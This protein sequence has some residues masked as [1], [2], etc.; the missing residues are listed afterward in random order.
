MGETR[1]FD[2]MVVNMVAVGE[3]TGELDRMLLRIADTYE[4][5]VDIEVASLVRLLEPLLIIMVG[6][7]VGFILFAVFL[8]L[9]DIIKKL[10]AS[11]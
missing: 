11:G 8:P 6:G 5:E 2:D 1:Q 10:G 3:E 9:L 4:Y 7:I